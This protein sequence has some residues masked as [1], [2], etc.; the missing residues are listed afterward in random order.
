[1]RAGRPPIPPQVDM[2]R[3]RSPSPASGIQPPPVARTAQAVHPGTA[4]RSRVLPGPPAVPASVLAGRVTATGCRSRNSMEGWSS[5]FCMNLSRQASPATGNWRATRP[6]CLLSFR[7]PRRAWPA[8]PRG[9]D[10]DPKRNAGKAVNRPARPT[11][12]RNGHPVRLAPAGEVRSPPTPPPGAPAKLGGAGRGRC[13]LQR[14][15]R[16]DQPGST[17]ANA[18]KAGRA[19]PA[20]P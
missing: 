19:A 11:E 18:R 15:G 7:L 8:P 13:Q 4:T 9:W 20:G 2:R 3:P 10:N 17:P 12:G 16:R 6:T 5:S 1:M 14:A